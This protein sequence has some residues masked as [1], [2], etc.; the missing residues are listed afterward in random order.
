M[1]RALAAW[2]TALPRRWLRTNGGEFLNA[3]AIRVGSRVS[4]LRHGPRSEWS[5]MY[6]S[7]S[8]AVELNATGPWGLSGS[9]L[10]SGVCSHPACQ[11]LRACP[12]LSISDDLRLP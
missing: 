10:D 7:R 11:T 1:A 2:R 4:S 6:A 3:H 8:R 5:L 12:R 9:R